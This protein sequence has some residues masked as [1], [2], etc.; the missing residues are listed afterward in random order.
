MTAPPPLQV[1]VERHGDVLAVLLD[2]PPVNA[3][4]RQM[5]EELRAAF[6][7]AERD[8]SLRAVVLAGRGAH[9]AAGA[10]LREFAAMADAAAFE[11]ASALAGETFASIESMPV[12]AIAAVDGWCLGGGNELAMACHMRVAGAGARFGQPEAKLGLIPGYGGTQRLPRLVGRGAALKL[13]LGG[14]PIDAAEALRIGLVDEIAPAGRTAFEHAMELAQKIAG[15][16]AGSVARILNLA[17]MDDFE[18]GIA[19]ERDAFGRCGES[20]DGREGVAAFLAKRIPRFGD[21][22]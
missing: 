2:R 11:A 3:I 17:R 19:M 13:M 15:F 8:A 18:R 4:G 20:P 14:E 1:A 6:A 5:L 21:S 12:P 22:S 16:G 9:F 7:E 10:D